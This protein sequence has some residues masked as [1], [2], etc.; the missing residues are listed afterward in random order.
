MFCFAL[1]KI[2]LK[3]IQGSQGNEISCS[4]HNYSLSITSKFSLGIGC[5]SDLLPNIFHF[6]ESGPVLIRPASFFLS[7]F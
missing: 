6:P 3:K 2:N 7:P 1:E 4:D 5:C